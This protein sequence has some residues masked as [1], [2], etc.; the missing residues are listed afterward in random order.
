VKEADT[1][2]DR[3]IISMNPPALLPMAIS[4]MNSNSSQPVLDSLRSEFRAKAHMS[5]DIFLLSPVDAVD[6]IQRGIDLGLMLAGVD[7]F[8]TLHTG[9]LELRWEFSNDIADTEIPYEEFVVSTI[10]LIQAESSQD[11]LFDV[12]FDMSTGAYGQ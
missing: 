7:G 10:D 6:F 8:I 1:W 9:C 5:E 4:F 3:E 11:V 12:V 2:D